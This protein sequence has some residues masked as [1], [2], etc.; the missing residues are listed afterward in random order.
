[1]LLMPVPLHR[2]RLWSRGFNQS[3]LIADALA[4]RTGISCDRHRLLRRRRTPPLRGMSPAERDS[5][6]RGAFTLGAGTDLRGRTI[7]LIDDVMTSGATA[8]ACAALLKRG[9][10]ENVHLLC[11]AKVLPDE[12]TG[13]HHD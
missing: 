10:A 5:A 3:A 12:R 4:R 7:L 2:W 9:G 13:R 8:N 1:M 6:V 11:W